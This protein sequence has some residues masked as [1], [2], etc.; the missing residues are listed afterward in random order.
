M[1][2]D[3]DKL[4]RQSFPNFGMLPGSAEI[5]LAGGELLC[6]LQGWLSP[7][8]PWKNY[9][10]AR[11]S[12]HSETGAWFVKGNT[13]SEWKVSGP[14]SLLWI[15]GKRRSPS[16]NLPFNTL[17]FSFRSW[18]WQECPLVRHL[19]QIFVSRTYGVRQLVDH[20]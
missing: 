11:K 14:S 8:D 1:T 18:R 6:N 5:L 20:R 16:N 9:H 13:L 3:T 12:R 17:I 2:S 10:V 7:P 19:F 15:N 4:K